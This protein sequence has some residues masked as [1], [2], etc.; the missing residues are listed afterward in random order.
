MATEGPRATLRKA[1]VSDI[2]RGA[3]RQIL[4]GGIP[5]WDFDALVTVD[6][7]YDKQISQLIRRANNEGWIGD[8]VD[9]VL[10]AREGKASF[11]A[12]VRPIAD[13]IKKDGEL[14]PDEAPEGR[15][16]TPSTGV[17]IFLSFLIIGAALATRALSQELSPVLIPAV[18]LALLF[19]ALGIA[20]L[21]A[22]RQRLLVDLYAT[23]QKSHQGSWGQWARAGNFAGSQRILCRQ[24]GVATNRRT[25]DAITASRPK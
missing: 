10:K 12:A 19:L 3:L 23:D 17:W 11:V 20:T 16:P 13:Q 2:D 5:S 22:P 24:C 25:P 14:P 4:D 9:A 18:I 7:A 8:L 1:I 6:A 21:I 15:I